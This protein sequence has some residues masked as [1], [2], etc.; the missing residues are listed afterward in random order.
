MKKYLP[1]LLISFITIAL[2]AFIPVKKY[3]VA[4]KTI[5]TGA[6]QTEKYLSYL[7]GKRVAILA[8]PTSIIG[9][10]HMVDSLQLLVV[11]I[12]KVFCPEHGFWGIESSGA[13]V[14]Y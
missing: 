12:V 11:D 13:K 9:H 3:P 1:Q 10:T 2:V 5:K 8:N 7:K 14:A 6:D 4:K